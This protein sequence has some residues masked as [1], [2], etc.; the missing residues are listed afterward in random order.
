MVRLGN[1]KRPVIGRRMGMSLYE[2]DV[3]GDS[4]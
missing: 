3:A 2:R 1:D 4:F